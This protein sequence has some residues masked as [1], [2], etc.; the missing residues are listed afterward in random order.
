M[1]MGFLKF[2]KKNP[3]KVCI[4]VNKKKEEKKNITKCG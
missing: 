2:N 3:L 1:K 4:P